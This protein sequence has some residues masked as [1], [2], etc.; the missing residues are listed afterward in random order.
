MSHFISTSNLV[1]GKP[2]YFYKNEK[3][4]TSGNF[5]NAGQVIL[6]NCSDS[7]IENLNVSRASIGILLH[8]SNNNTISGNDANYNSYG[9]YLRSSSNNTISGNDASYNDYGIYLR[10]SS[11]NTI[12]GNNASYNTN[13]G[14]S[15]K[16]CNNNTISGNN[17]S[18]NTNYGIY[19]DSSI[20]TTIAENIFSKNYRGIYS[21]LCDYTLIKYNLLKANDDTGIMIYNGDYNNISGNFIF[22]SIFIGLHLTSG[23]GSNKIYN[24]T[25]RNTLNVKNEGQYNNWSENSLGN[26]WNDYFG[27]DVNDDGIGDIPYPI[28]GSSGGQDDYPILWDSPVISILTPTSNQKVEVT[29]PNFNISIIEGIANATWYSIYDGIEWSANYTTTGLSGQINQDLWDTLPDGSFTIRFYSNDSR[30]YVGFSDIQVTKLV[31]PEPVE[32]PQDPTM[33]IIWIII[34]IALVAIASIFGVAYTRKSRKKLREKESEVV[35]LEKIKSEL[36]EEDFLISKERRICLVHKGVADGVM[37][38]CSK[39][40]AVYCFKCYEAVK[41]LE[42]A[43]W[44]CSSPLDPQKPVKK[45]KK[46]EKIGISDEDVEKRDIKHKKS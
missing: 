2:L 36:T 12:S 9:I 43:C 10:E 24:N 32:I 6:A 3:Y 29:S 19:L 37:Y 44:S 26:S 20:T 22:D 27:K 21:S 33:F 39:C 31:P 30:G 34:L 45:L 1:N 23:S 46:D 40:G 7:I 42:N 28:L 14:I 5:S 11:N 15:L 35:E 18:Y 41:D 8:S 16:L 38:A 17:A 25:F 13:D 4:L